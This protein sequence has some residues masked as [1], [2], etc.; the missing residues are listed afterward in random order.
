METKATFVSLIL[1]GAFYICI[2]AYFLNKA[3]RSE[4]WPK[5]SATIKHCAIVE[6]YD[7]APTF[8]TTISYSY[9]INKTQYD[10]YQ[11]YD[12]YQATGSYEPHKAI[13]EYLKDAQTV[14][15][16]YNPSNPSDSV[17]AYGLSKQHLS[18]IIF[19]GLFVLITV[20]ATLY[21]FSPDTFNNPIYWFV[22]CSIFFSGVIG[23]IK[24]LASVEDNIIQRI[25][26][27]GKN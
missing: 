11:I 8:Q 2:G 3:R 4:F 27:L 24:L 26:I 10:G 13:Y 7:E 14:E 1:F 20:M 23:Y 18:F 5:T 19:G 17:I 16:R 22:V 6:D 21:K 12:G 25:K 15:V 9:T